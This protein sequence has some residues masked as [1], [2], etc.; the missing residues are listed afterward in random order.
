[1]K[2]EAHSSVHFRH[3]FVSGGRQTCDIT[4]AVVVSDRSEESCEIKGIGALYTEP[5]PDMILVRDYEEWQQYY[6]R[7]GMGLGRPE[8]Q[9]FTRG[10]RPVEYEESDMKRMRSVAPRFFTRLRKK[11]WRWSRLRENSVGTPDN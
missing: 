8:I 6:F 9:L 7:G 10:R 3:E 1:M 11:P 4:V 2:R 5:P